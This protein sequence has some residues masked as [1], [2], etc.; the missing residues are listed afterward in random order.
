MRGRIVM[1]EPRERPGVFR[2]LF[3]RGHDVGDLRDERVKPYRLAH[4]GTLWMQ[5]WRY[6]RR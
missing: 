4:Q 5:G 1:C 2:P 6:V 3:M